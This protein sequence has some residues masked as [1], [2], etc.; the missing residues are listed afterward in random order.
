MPS[1]LLQA[2]PGELVRESSQRKVLEAVG[3]MIRVIG[4]QTDPA[5]LPAADTGRSI[6]DVIGA[7]RAASP[8]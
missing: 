5:L 8:T 7:G 2:V 4:K 1:S 6:L 3:K